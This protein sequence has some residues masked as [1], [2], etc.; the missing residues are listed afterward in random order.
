MEL[1]EAYKLIERAAAAGRVVLRTHS[2]GDPPQF[3]IS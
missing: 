2:L 3:H 1:D